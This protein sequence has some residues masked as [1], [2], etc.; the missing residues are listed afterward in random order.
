MPTPIKGWKGEVRIIGAD[1]NN[2]W[3]DAAPDPL[4]ERSPLSTSVP[5]DKVY[6]IGKKS[7]V[8]ILEGEQEITGTVE[9]AFF[10]NESANY[11]A[12]VGGE[13]KRLTDLAGVTET[14]MIECKMRIRPNESYDILPGYI[15]KG[16]KFSDWGL[17]MAAGDMTK[18]HADYSATDVEK[19]E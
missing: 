11:V 17:D 9:R 5:T 8:A 18:E 12:I 1:D 6:V 2:S 10:D 13:L 16:V 4:L 7:P 3:F 19:E 14:E 15:L